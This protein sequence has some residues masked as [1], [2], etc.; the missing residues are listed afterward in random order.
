MLRQRNKREIGHPEEPAGSAE[1]DRQ[2]VIGHLPGLGGQRVILMAR[3]PFLRI[4]HQTGLEVIPLLWGRGLDPFRP[5]PGRDR[6]IDEPGQVVVILGRDARPYSGDLSGGRRMLP[7]TPADDPAASQ[8][9]N[10]PEYLPLSPR[11]IHAASRSVW[12]LR[13]TR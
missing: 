9:G 4:R 5:E 1:P 6:Q 12:P 11:R 7:I 8:A 13:V 3:E 2:V 10:T